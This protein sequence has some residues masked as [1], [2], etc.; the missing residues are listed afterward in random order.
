[1]WY[2]GCRGS[3]PGSYFVERVGGISMEPLIDHIHITVEN[4]GRA[5]RY[6]DQLL[7]LL[8]FDPSL[9]EHDSEPE[10]EYHIVEYHSNAL[11]IGLVNRRDAY[12]Y[13]KVSRRRAGALHHL[14]FHAGS[15]EEVDALYLKIKEIPSVIVH[16]AKYYPEYCPDYYAFFFK[17]SEGIE[18]EIVHFNRAEYFPKQKG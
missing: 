17:D 2:N 15:P 13:E 7:P 5:E 8:G 4:L 6:Y 1:M 11:S 9:K 3:C 14:A 12:K 16:G 18:Y 10:H